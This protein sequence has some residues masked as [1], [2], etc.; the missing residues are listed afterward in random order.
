MPIVSEVPL[1]VHDAIERGSLCP[2]TDGAWTIF[3]EVT[4]A[5]CCHTMRAIFII[6][7]QIDTATSTYSCVCWACDSALVAS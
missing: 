6:R 4:L 2:T 1:A 7:Q 5:P 3:S